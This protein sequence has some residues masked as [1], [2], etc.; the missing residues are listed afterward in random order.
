M[1]YTTLFICKNKMLNLFDTLSIYRM[2]FIVSVAS[3]VLLTST[4]I[5]SKD[6]PPIIDLYY[7]Q[8]QTVE[9]SHLHQSII[10]LQQELHAAQQTITA[11]QKTIETLNRS[12]VNDFF[13][14]FRSEPAHTVTNPAQSSL[15]SA[16]AE[17]EWAR[18]LNLLRTK[19]YT[20]TIYKLE[21]FIQTYPNHLYKARGLNLL[22][23]LFLLNGDTQQAI[24]YLEQCMAQYP[25][26]DALP[27]VCFY[28]GLAHYARKDN[29][30]AHQYFL[31][32]IQDYP[33]HHMT[34]KAK[35]HIKQLK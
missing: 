19:Q 5:Y 32:L 10:K 34:Q 21:Q 35:A 8:G 24:T 20:K 22:G 26:H 28:L 12:R 1:Q 25:D 16:Y 23:Q 33:D 29:P 27:E 14:L 13:N 17:K 31:K 11:Q 30:R 2:R 6:L 15:A 3:I 7:D 4:H 9:L 18:I